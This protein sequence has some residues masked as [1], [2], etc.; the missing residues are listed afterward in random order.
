MAR[1]NIKQSD[2]SSSTNNSVKI[3]TG[4]KIEFVTGSSYEGK[5]RKAQSEY[6][7]T[8]S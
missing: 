4:S 3:E 7:P 6:Q 2:V 1:I 8:S 5:Y